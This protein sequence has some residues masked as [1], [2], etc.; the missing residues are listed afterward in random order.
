MKFSG[1]NKI[2]SLVLISFLLFPALCWSQDKVH[3]WDVYSVTFNSAEIRSNPYNEI[4][5][6][7]GVGFLLVNFQGTSGEALNKSFKITGFWNGGSEWRVNFAPPF[8][9]NW[10]YSSASPDKG[11]NGR[12][13]TFEVIPWT[14]D[15]KNANPVRRGFV[16]VRKS[17]ET[18]G[19]YFEYS[20]GKPFLWI[21]DTWWNWTNRKIK[22]ETFRELVDNRAEKGF[23][24]GQIFVGA[25]GWGRESSLLD[26]TFTILDSEHM[27]RVEEMIK[28]ANSKGITV[29]IHGW[30]SREN[31]NTTAGAE[32]IKRYWRYLVHRFAAYNVIWVVAGEYNMY[33]YGGFSLDFWKE[34]GGLIKAEDPYERIVSLH[35][36]PPFWDGGAAAP[37]WSTGSVLHNEPWLDYNQSQVGHGKFANEMIPYIINEEYNRKPSKPIVITEPWYEFIEGNPTGMDIRF[38]A[39]SAILSGAAGHTYG[40]GHV[41]LAS[42]PE[43]PGG[44]GSWPYE[45]GFERTT[46]DYEGAVSMKYLASFFKNIKWW[47]MT[48]HPELILEY[49]QPFCLAKPGREYVIYLRYAGT[50]KVKMDESALAYKFRYNWYDPGTGKVYDSK[51]IEGRKVLQF[52]C[53]ESFPGTPIYKDWVLY[54]CKE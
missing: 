2:Q 48:P 35:N 36:T 24:V 23:N 21:G 3:Q 50:V 52:N 38:G 33:N 29:W 16:R 19:H 42:V 54:I 40:G 41:W 20:D 34:L 8:T 30:W 37:Q 31:L 12:K 45:K 39:W 47:E 46:Y 15:E 49:P 27:K 4:S 26:E 32:K 18:A 25:N 10:K 44:G 7:A 17:G 11:L 5:P 9:G 6:S 22:P 14:E 13:G 53:P 1:S 43:A 51:I 28:Y